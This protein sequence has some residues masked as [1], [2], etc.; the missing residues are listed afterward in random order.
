M[1]GM[2]EEGEKF[3]VSP[4]SGGG[5]GGVGEG[6]CHAPTHL[7]EV[8]EAALIGHGFVVVGGDGSSELVGE[9]PVQG[10]VGAGGA[11]VDLEEIALRLEE[12]EAKIVRHFEHAG[13]LVGI[14]GHEAQSAQIVEQAGGIGHFAVE[15]IGRASCR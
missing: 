7:D 10:E 4:V 12:V 5:G 11:V 2:R 3:F 8:V 14:G 6:I 9:M 15:E 13:V 1:G